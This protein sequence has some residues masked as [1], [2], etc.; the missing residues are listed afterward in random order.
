MMAQQPSM[1]N[2]S[3]D[4]RLARRHGNNVDGLAKLDVLQFLAPKYA[5]A[6]ILLL[7]DGRFRPQADI[8]SAYFL[9]WDPLIVLTNH[10]RFVQINWI[11]DDDLPI[12][13]NS[14]RCST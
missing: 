12:Q 9:A 5:P 2:Y 10:R 1:R 3:T 4:L 11:G 7:T 13:A 8:Q 14:R 6:C